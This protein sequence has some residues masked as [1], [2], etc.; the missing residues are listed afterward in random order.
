MQEFALETAEVT[1]YQD[2]GAYI[3][4]VVAENSARRAVTHLLRGEEEGPILTYAA[5]DRVA[6]S[7]GALFQARGAQGERA[8]MLFEAGVEPIAA[9]LGCLYAKVIAVPL[10][11]PVAGRVERYLPRV[12]SVVKDAE[13]KFVLT[14]TDILQ[15]LQGLASKIPAFAQVEWIAMDTLADLA[16]E[17]KEEAIQESDI[18]YLQYTSGSTSVPKGVMISHGNLLKICEYDSVLLEFPKKGRGT[19]CWMPYFHDAGLIEGLL[20]PIYNGLPV[21]IMSPLDFVSHPVRWLKAIS[22]Y[23]A[24]HSAGPNFAFE[25]CVRKTT[26]EERQAL[27]LSCWQR[28]SISAEPINSATVER[29]IDAFDCCGFEA[30][31]LS[32]AWGLAEA[33]LAVTGVAGATFHKLDA[34]ELEQN[35]I[36]YSSGNGPAKTMVGCGKV[37]KGPWTVNVRIVDPETCKPAPVGTVGEVWVNGDLIAQGY[38][39]RPTDTAETFQAQIK[40]ENGAHFLRTGDLG[41]MVGDE[42][43]FTGRRKDLI[44]VEG[45]NHYPQDIERTVERSHR[46]LRAGCSIAFSLEDDGQAKVV[47]VAEL[48]KEFRLDEGPVREGDSRLPISH[49]EIAK[50]VRIEVAEEHQIRVH[51]LVLISAGTIP[52][53][54]SGKLQRVACKQKFLAGTLGA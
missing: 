18:A 38:W 44:I 3:R 7:L 53:T 14:T 5:L 36:V 21:Y 51:K 50:A 29:F 8:I 33:T 54:T 48:D 9:F 39:N 19:V 35:R 32:P 17:W 28:A 1:S 25:L 13:V 46:A 15:Q 4:S 49:K 40:G 12:E 42:F 43:V 2:F 47:V 23:R 10:P 45:R 34:A 37:S 16:G 22:R 30:K 24:S 11:A 26:P 52:K 27:N 41:F 6:R 31:A 20:V